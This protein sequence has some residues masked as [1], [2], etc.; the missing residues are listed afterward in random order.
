M[1]VSFL[2]V[3]A[4][5]CVTAAAE[6]PA[7]GETFKIASFSDS[8]S[9]K[10]FMGVT[11]SAGGNS[12]VEGYDWY[13]T[14]R[15]WLLEES[16][17]I[18]GPGVV[19]SLHEIHDARTGLAGQDFDLLI[20]SEV[21][22][23][24]NGAA[25]EEAAAIAE[26]VLGGGC[27]AIVADTLDGGQGVVMGN[28]TL[29]ALDGGLGMAGRYGSSVLT[30]SEFETASSGHFSLDVGAS[31]NLVWGGGFNYQ[32]DGTDSGDPY[33]VGQNDVLEN[34]RFGVTDH[35]AVVPGSWGQVVGKRAISTGP[36]PTLSDVIMEIPG[37]QI[38]AGLSLSGAGNVMVVG[39][40]I[41]SNKMVYPIA[42]GFGNSDPSLNRNNHNNAR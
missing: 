5:V 7:L 19:V 20:M 41:F 28:L 18:F 26:F 31:S 14:M 39:D 16:P 27:L 30:G 36:D 32:I 9:Y 23:L 42:D 17:G 25:D 21:V 24:A 29:G 12:N 1:R 22:P 13:S 11:G 34:A 10:Y 33:A 37:S 2:L 6:N 15:D 3:L 35:V 8:R 40:T 38:D 4:G